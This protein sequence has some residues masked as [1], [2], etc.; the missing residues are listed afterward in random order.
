MLFQPPLPPQYA[1]KTEEEM[2]S[3]VL[4]HKRAL[5][6]RLV[7]LGHH[8]QRHE[9]IRFAD[10]T[11]DSLR[12]SQLGAR[13]EGAE[14]IIFCGVHFMAE[15]A[16]ILTD[17]SVK[18]VLPDL[19]AGCSMADMADLDQLEDAWDFLTGDCN[20]EPVPITYINSTAAIK[21]FCGAHDG[22]CCTSSNAR[23]ILEWALEHLG[24]TPATP[25]GFPSR[26]WSCT[27][28]GSPTA[29]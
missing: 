1:A 22:A 19:S 29:A 26:R 13:Q 15:S 6:S 27:T 8:Y 3:T 21:A 4:G 14:F 12:L 23:A 18:V 24:R 16:D 9:V 20:V 11:G 5:G 10:F 28:P 17:D 7:I 2:A 25:W